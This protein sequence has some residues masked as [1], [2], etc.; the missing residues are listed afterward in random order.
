MMSNEPELVSFVTV[1]EE[2]D[3]IVSFFVLEPD[4][5]MTGR[6]IILMRTPKYEPLLPIEEWGVSV[7]DEEVDDDDDLVNL[8]QSIRFDGHI[9]EIKSTALHHYLD[10]HQVEP[11]ELDA[12]KKL[13]K[14]MNRDKRFELIL[15]QGTE[16]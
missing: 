16:R 14:K 7:S 8:L 12:A 3:Q 13:L 10:V 9:V 15:H 2:D 6:S 1:E 11:E 4:D 5:W